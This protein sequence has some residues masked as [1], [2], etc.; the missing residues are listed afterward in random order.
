L[1]VTKT[2][3][4]STPP[5][6][7]TLRRSSDR[8]AAEGKRYRLSIVIPT[9]NEADNI[10]E[11]QRELAGALGDIDYEIVI[12]DDSTDRITRP[13]LA[14]T[15]GGDS[16]WHIIE[17]P[18]P[19]Q[20]GLGTAVVEGLRAARGRWICVMD[21][22]LQHPPALIPRLLAAV[23]AGADLAVASRYMPGGSRKGLAGTGRLMVSRGATWLARALFPEARRTTDPLTGF[24]CCRREAIA[25]LEYRPLGFKI[26]LELLVCNETLKVVDVPLAFRDRFAGESKASTAQGI[27]YLKHLASLFVYVPDSARPVKFGLV[28]L[29][30][31]SLFFPLLIMLKPRIAWLAAWVVAMTLS[32]AVALALHRVFT[33]RDVAVN[34]D[35]DLASLYYG[36]AAATLVASVLAG[37]IVINPH[38]HPWLL[39]AAATQFG[40]LGLTLFL[41]TSPARR[42]LR[43]RLHLMA[44]TD[45]AAVG[46]RL[47][48]DRVW[49]VDPVTPRSPERRKLARAISQG[50]IDSVAQR[51]KPMLWVET[52]SPRPQARVNVEVTSALLVPRPG[53]D[54]QTPSVA[55]VARHTTKPFETRHLRLAVSWLDGMAG[56]IGADVRDAA[57]VGQA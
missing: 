39:L 17:R 35:P 57:I 29:A 22:D 16:R 1:G 45:L 14:A 36:G 33:F 5:A 10:P 34:R 44:P 32:A 18:S 3:I 52:P 28:S 46:R 13:A 51:R 19:E 25:G 47:G 50:V 38:G 26:L 9:R 27:L 6:S 2:N 48:A 40:A 8:L 55:V 23:E 56:G 30:S 41:N 15:A 49:W 54:G 20:T 42:F 24:F 4:R 53:P 11:L 21:G 37:A 43:A 12:V 31:L 7:T